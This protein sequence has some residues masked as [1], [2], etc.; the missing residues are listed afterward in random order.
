MSEARRFPFAGNLDPTA[1]EFVPGTSNPI[2]NAIHFF[3]PTS[4]FFPYPPPPPPPATAFPPLL[5]PP[6]PQYPNDLQ[7]LPFYSPP[8]PPP[9]TSPEPLLP[10]TSVAPT[11]AVV[12][13]SVAADV[14][15]SAVRRDVE[16]FGEIRG[17]QMERAVEGIVT[18]HFYDI[19]N[20]QTALT[21]IRERHMQQQFRYSS[22]VNGGG[23]FP[24]ERGLVVGRA[25]WA[26]YAVPATGAVVEGNNQGTLVV[27]NL[28]PTIS[29]TSL[30]EIFQ[31]YGAVKE[32]R[33]TPYKKHQRF[34]EFYDVRDAAKALMEMNGRE[35]HGKPVVIQFSRPG[36]FNK[37]LFLSSQQHYHN[38]HLLLL[39]PPPPPPQDFSGHHPRRRFPHSPPR[40][41]PV[42]HRRGSSAVAASMAALSLRDDAERTTK[43]YVKK[44]DSS[45]S[46]HAY[47]K[48][49]QERNNNNGVCRYYSRNNNKPS[50]KI[51]DACYV[52]NEDAISESSGVCRDERTTLMIK[53]IPNKY[54]QQMLLNMLDSHCIHCNEEEDAT[55]SSYDFVYLPIDFNNKCNVGYGF[56]NMTSPQAA[57]KLYKA[58]HHQHWEVFNSRKIC[59]VTYARV[60]GLEAL[61]EHFKNS[62]FPCE[63]EEYVP[64]AFSPPRDGRNF[65]EPVPIVDV[66][67]KIS[68][69]DDRDHA[70]A[71]DDDGK[72]KMDDD[73]DDNDDDACGGSCDKTEMNNRFDGC[74]IG[75][76]GGVGGED[77]RGENGG[78]SDHDED[79][80][81]D[82]CNN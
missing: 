69:N 74:C 54:S 17:V 28:D 21:E 71:H 9:E 1:R 29:N 6:P 76:G 42:Y 19:R 35:I 41:P 52:I 73:Y 51:R 82:A 24:A 65:S 16:V 61:K 40:K 50:K 46:D 60:Q 37:R 62:K 26:H 18:V 47:K 2:P 15:E 5:L 20:A 49:H 34:V 48:H 39:P 11:R 13:I 30:R 45:S 56:V 55:L 75:G 14:S 10:P 57:W 78:V 53:N 22:G 38:K 7:F 64:V 23:F 63:T 4:V 44:S 70:H 43:C 36:G 80:D 81:V 3:T 68:G 67:G 27:L 8:P 12:L 59:E 33:E 25:V 72:N 58:F 32:L 66:V 79:D 31:V 77:G